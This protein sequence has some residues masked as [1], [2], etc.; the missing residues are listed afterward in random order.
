MNHYSPN[1]PILLVGTKLDLRED[2]KMLREL[3]Q[4]GEG[5][6]ITREE[7]EKKRKEWKVHKY[8]ECSAKTQYGVKEGKLCCY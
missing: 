8:L 1:T 2:S 6:P 3:E 4:R 7:A 5:P